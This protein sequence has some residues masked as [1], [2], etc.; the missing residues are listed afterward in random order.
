MSS[1]SGLG[2]NMN[3]LSGMFPGMP[4][5][6]GSSAA[7]SPLNDADENR[8]RM[9]N[10]MQGLQNMLGSQSSNMPMFGTNPFFSPPIGNP[11]ASPQSTA[12]E[13][14]G[15]NNSRER[16]SSQLSTMA[17]MGFTDTDQCI[18]ALLAAVSF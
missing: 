1:L 4:V 15:L 11:V 10:M 14:S 5:F 3:S 2:G 7:A 13:P 9:G 8:Q 6:P 17:D 18:R 12:P 16:F